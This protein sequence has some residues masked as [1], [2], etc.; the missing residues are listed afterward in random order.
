MNTT[1]EEIYKIFF[2]KISKDKDFFQYFNVSDEEALE[3]A[4]TRSES[5]LKSALV[6][7][8][9]YCA[10]DIDFYN[11]DDI[12]NQFNF[13]CTEIE[14]DLIAELMKEGLLQQ[15]EMKLKVVHGYFNTKDLKTFSPANERKTFVEMLEK[16]YNRNNAKIENYISKDRETGKY[17]TLNFDYEV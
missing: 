8:M 6:R 11:Y 15:D 10:P 12:N 17:K 5:L 4:Q 16:I 13:E 7:I 9:N 14:K 3:I 2:D 1:F